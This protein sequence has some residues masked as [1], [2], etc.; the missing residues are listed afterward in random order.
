METDVLI[1]GGGPAGLS[2]AYETASRGLNVT[3]IEETWYLG[4]QLVQQTQSF[5]DMPNHYRQLCG[6][7]IAEN[8]IKKVEPFG[9]HVLTDHTLIGLYEN[10]EMGISND[11]DVFP[12]KASKIIMATGAAEIAV[13]FPKWTLPG[14]MTAGAAQILI[15]RDRVLP[16]TKTILIG[17]S[18]FA[19]E[20]AKQLHEVGIEVKGIVEQQSDIVLQN[21]CLIDEIEKLNIPILKNTKVIEAEGKGQVETLV[22]ES[23]QGPQRIDVDFVCLDGGRNPILEAFLIANCSLSYRKILGGWVPDYDLNFE[24][25]S[26]GVYVA[27]NSTG[28]TSKAAIFLT[29]SLSGIS[30]CESLGKINSTEASQMKNLF[31]EELYQVEQQV[32][33]E[34]W[35]SRLKHIEGYMGP[36]SHQS[37]SGIGRKING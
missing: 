7:E 17:S 6:F 33:L 2:A 35:N 8:L 15:N 28:I 11:R 32:N 25:S 16:G 20:L 10:G 36:N 12:V 5:E 3:I 31:W 19:F 14:I 26:E 1:I 29:G 22:I 30:V 34:G 18:S 13:P 27:G 24:T 9:I 21:N 37:L 4:G 23:N